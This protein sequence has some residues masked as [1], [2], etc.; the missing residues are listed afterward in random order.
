ML[1]LLENGISDWLELRSFYALAILA[2]VGLALLF[3][4]RHGRTSARHRRRSRLSMRATR[5]GTDRD[6]R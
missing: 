4:R 6:Q 1:A 5:R 3:A 2:L